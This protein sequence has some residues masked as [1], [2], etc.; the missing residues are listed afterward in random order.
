MIRSGI[1]ALV[2][3]MV[4]VATAQQPGRIATTA[5]ALRAAP[6]FFHGR[7]VVILGATTDVNGLS[8]I[9]PLPS[10]AATAAG[11]PVQGVSRPIF[12]FWRERPT[13][14]TGEIRGEFWDLGRLTENDSRFTAFGFGALIEAV[15]NGRWP[16]RDQLFVVVNATLVDSTLPVAPTLRAIALAPEKYENSGVTVSGKFRGRNLYGDVAAPL[17]AA[18]KWDFV[19]QS[20]DASLWVT[21]V[22]P[23]GKGFDLDPGARVDTGKWVQVTGTVRREGSRA[24]LEAREIELS[25]PPDSTTVEIDVPS[26]PREP[27]P[28]VVFSAP[29]PDEGDVDRSAPIRIQFS[30]DMDGRTFKDR[31][32]VTYVPPAKGEAPPPPPIFSASY[33]PGNRGVEIK[34]AKPLERFQSVKVELQEGIAAVDGQTLPLWTLVF[35]TGS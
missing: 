13:R 11:A 33:N 28:T 14:S 8:R 4:G 31:I 2:L 30:R 23:K 6:V 22:R 32:R 29:V 21:G 15:N 18:T 1:G 5:A 34:F 17:A 26:L 24:W 25:S 9:D 10:G 19:L 16:A 12:A 3:V 35:S 27:P 20:A 7:H